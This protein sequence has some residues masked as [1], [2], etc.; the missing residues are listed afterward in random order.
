MFIDETFDINNTENCHISIQGNLNGYFFS[1]LDTHRKRLLLYT[2]WPFDEDTSPEEFNNR[3]SDLHKKDKYLSRQYA[4]VTFAY[5]AP[6]YTIVPAS[7]FDPGDVKP[8]F[9]FNHELSENEELFYNRL[10]SSDAVNIFAMPAG[11]KEKLSGWSGNIAYYN[12]ITPMV[13][14]FVRNYA[15]ADHKPKVMVNVHKGFV[16]VAVL[17]GNKL[18]LCNSY[19]FG[20]ERDF[21]YFVFSVFERLRLDRGETGLILMGEIDKESAYFKLLEKYIRNI[22]FEKLPGQ[23]SYDQN[24]LDIEPH[25]ITNLINLALCE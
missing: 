4:T 16:D 8:Y 20:D 5:S 7:F 12:H 24:F 1:I 2:H 19:T 18:K 14:H 25:R 10:E 15:E 21:A 6:R 3:V 13:E 9:T 23:L 22:H 11:L 17:K